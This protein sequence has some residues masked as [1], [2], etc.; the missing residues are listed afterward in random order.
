MQEQRDSI[1]QQAQALCEQ[2]QPI[3]G[4]AKFDRQEIEAID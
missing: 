4:S 2:D 1:A 3:P